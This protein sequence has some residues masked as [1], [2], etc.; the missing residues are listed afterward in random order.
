MLRMLYIKFIEYRST[1]L[2]T[3]E[4]L[5]GEHHLTALYALITTAGV[6]CPGKDVSPIIA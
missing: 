4:E 5:S 6:P 2:Q 1:T 3:S